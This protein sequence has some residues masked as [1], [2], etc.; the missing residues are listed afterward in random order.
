M[1]EFQPEAPAPVVETP[2]AGYNKYAH[3][4]ALRRRHL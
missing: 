4:A 1:V 3:A 2:P